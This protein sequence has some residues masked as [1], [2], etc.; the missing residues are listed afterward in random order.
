[1][2]SARTNLPL[3]AGPALLA[4]AGCAP[5]AG[6][7][8]AG[9]APGLLERPNLLVVVIDT[10]R[11]DGLGHN[12]PDRETSPA[13]DRLA[14]ESVRFERAYSSAPWTMPAVAS[15]LTGL[16]PSAHGVTEIKHKLPGRATT[17]AERLSEAGYTT[18]AVVSHHLIG[19]DKGFDQGYRS[20]LEQQSGHDRVSTPW[21]TEAA[22]GELR[23]LARGGAPFFLYV[24]YFDPHFN[25]LPHERYRYA[26]ER[27]GTLDGDEGIE[28]LRN[29]LAELTTDEAAFLRDLYDGE[30]RFTDDG[31]GELLRALERLELAPRTV[32]CF[33][34]DHGEEFLERGW[35]GHTRT[36]YDELVRVPFCVRLPGVAPRAVAVPVS[37]A[38][39]APTLLELAGLP[40]P[41]EVQAPSLLGLLTG[42]AAPEPFP[43]VFCEV[44][45]VQVPLPRKFGVDPEVVRMKNAHLKA[46]VAGRHK[47]IRDDASGA[48]E[49]YD[50]EADPLEARD[51]AAEEPELTARLAAELER[52]CARAREGGVGPEELEIDAKELERLRRLGYVDGGK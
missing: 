49:L 43:A 10:L 7:A 35:L 33:T 45:F 13:I 17:L 20:F 12:R 24:H 30:V 18:A 25:Y 38:S 29:R 6:G 11:F 52:A 4:L 36:L 22:V 28:E 39:L 3:I 34:S 15:M 8:A 23:E 21:V 27:A 5:D 41:A 50:L 9:D 32:V 31:V 40:V 48:L 44:D 47:L 42:A 19:R 14:A 2:A 37:T 26:P 1:M 51:L 46:L 16:Y